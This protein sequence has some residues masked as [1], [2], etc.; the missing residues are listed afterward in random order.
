MP[1]SLDGEPGVILHTR[2]YKENSLL[3][4]LYT[5]NYGRISAVTKLS[6]R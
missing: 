2:P 3:V 1:V 4:E 5:L 6:K